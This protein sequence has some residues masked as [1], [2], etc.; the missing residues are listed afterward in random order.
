MMHLTI[1]TETSSVGKDGAFYNDLDLTQCQIPNDVWALQWNSSSGWIEFNKPVPNENI[2][3][4]PAWA[5]S[6]LSVWEAK[7]YVEKHPPAPTPEQIIAANKLQA[8]NLLAESD[9]SVL[10]DVPLVN[11]SEWETY[12]SAL[13][14]IAIN[15]TIDPTWP[16]KPQTIWQ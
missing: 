4:L 11:K 8:E 3:S 10:P 1:I 15:P 7:D 16:T 5:N 6:C 13:R 2:T 12:R 9:W 14:Q